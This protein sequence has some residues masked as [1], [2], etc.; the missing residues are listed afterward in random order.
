MDPDILNQ[1]QR[2]S[3]TAEEKAEIAVQQSHH[4]KTLEECSVNLFGR[5]LTNKPYNQRAAK[6]LF[7]SFW[8]LENELKIID[9]GN[10]VY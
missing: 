5:L 3:L 9:V 7:R 2:I 10:G 8:K 1:I 4:E 6:N